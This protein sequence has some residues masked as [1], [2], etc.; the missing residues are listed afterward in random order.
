MRTILLDYRKAFDLIDDSI[1]RDK[2]YKLELSRSVINWIIDFLSYRLQQVRLTDGCFSEWGFVPSGVPQGTKLG[3]WLF[4]V[5]I[6]DLN[7]CDIKNADMWKYVDDATTSK[8]RRKEKR[9]TLSLYTLCIMPRLCLGP[10]NES[11]QNK[12]GGFT[13]NLFL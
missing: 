12:A 3:P 1:L 13:L 10:G 6:N 5:L 8:V 7:L 4:L 9:E 11:Y 2:L